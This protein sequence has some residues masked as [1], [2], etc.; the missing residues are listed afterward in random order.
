MLTWKPFWSK[1]CQYASMIIIFK[2]LEHKVNNYDFNATRQIAFD[3]NAMLCISSS[4]FIPCCGQQ[5]RGK[6][7]AKR[8]WGQYNAGCRR[9]TR[10]QTWGWG[11]GVHL[12]VA[13]PTV[14]VLILLGLWVPSM[15]IRPLPKIPL[16]PLCPLC[17]HKMIFWPI[18][19]HLPGENFSSSIPLTYLEF[20]FSFLYLLCSR[21]ISVCL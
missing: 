3:H 9:S 19:C 6:E 15:S 1:W 12:Y 16:C 10:G 18:I 17:P 8:W 20:T 11:L 21:T 13:D 14:L 2:C 7:V 5:W 4:V